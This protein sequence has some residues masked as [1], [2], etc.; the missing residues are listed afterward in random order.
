MG[1]GASSSNQ[2]YRVGLVYSIMRASELYVVQ[3]KLTGVILRSS[4][5]IDN[6]AVGPALAI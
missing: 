2:N 1:L 3:L 6:R 4:F 5:P